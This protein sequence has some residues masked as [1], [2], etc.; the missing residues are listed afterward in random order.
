MKRIGIILLIIIFGVLA[1]YFLIKSHDYQ[2]DFNVEA[3][4]GTVYQTIKSWND[5][6]DMSKIIKVEGIYKITQELQF[7][8]SIHQYSWNIRPLNDS[9]SHISVYATDMDHSMRN[10]I[11]IPFSDTNF[12]KRTRQSLLDFNNKLNEHLESIK[13]Q[14]VG[15]SEIRS[16]Y[17][18][19]TTLSTSQF[20][21]ARGMMKDYPLLNGI[22]ANNNV[23]LDGP[24]ILEVTRWN[25]E[26]DSLE[27]NFCYPIIKSDSL[28]THPQIHYKQIR[29]KKAIKA[30]YN[31]NYI[32]SDRAWYAL[33]DYAKRTHQEVTALPLEI[34]YN[35]PN[36]GGD[37]LRWK[38]EIFMPLKIQHE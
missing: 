38:A 4:A 23:V 20:N 26:K 6:Q 33:L 34:F 28:P 21:K 30:V 12:E 16:A 2:V 9:T 14:V 3:N 13:V 31:G 19:C 25:M 1:W 7:N 22:L 18:A 37:E 35:N 10:K 27:F 5:V 32:T 24:P 15:M 8:D 11:A 36:M 29:S 17:C